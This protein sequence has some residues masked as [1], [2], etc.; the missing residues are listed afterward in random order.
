MAG[1]Q[2][3]RV[4]SSPDEVAQRA[5]D[6]RHREALAGSAAGPVVNGAM[7]YGSEPRDLSWNASDS[8]RYRMEVITISGRAAEVEFRI[9]RESVEIWSREHCCA[10]LDRQMLRAWLAAPEA[11]ALV[12]DEVTFATDASGRAALDLPHV[13]LWPLAPHVLAGLRDR[14]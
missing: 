14:V 7:S 11:S 2:Q 9:R 1:Y 8:S 10:V 12:V 13:G 6:A 4:S 5:L 3:V